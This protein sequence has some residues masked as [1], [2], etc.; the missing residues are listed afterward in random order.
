M[1]I[2]ENNTITD[3]DGNTYNV[4]QIGKQLWTA[5]NLN[6]SKYRNGDEIPQVQDAEEWAHLETGAWCYYDNKDENGTSYGKL[7]NWYAFNDPRGLAPEGFYIPSDMEWKTLT[8]YLGGDN[9]A[10]GKMKEKGS[11]HFDSP[12]NNAT[13]ESVFSGLTGGCRDI[14]LFSGMDKIG[15]WWASSE[16]S[17]N[18]SLAYYQKIFDKGESIM[19]D[20]DN[21]KCG[22]SVRLLKDSTIIKK[23]KIG[24]AVI[25]KIIISDK[26]GNAYNGVQIGKQLWM[27]ENL[28]VSKYRNGDEIPQ[29]QDEKEWGE[30]TTGAWC[31][32]KNDKEYGISYG[33][34]YNWHAINDPRGLA[35]EGFHI[36][37]DLELITLTEYI[38]PLK[39][40]EKL[41]LNLFRAS[42]GGYR[43]VHSQ[44]YEFSAGFWWSST[45]GFMSNSWEQKLRYY[46][47]YPRRYFYDKQNGLSVRCI[48]D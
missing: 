21:K 30:L 8:K 15:V 10:G 24:S 19:G 22:F 4:V 44:F 16:Y 12:N 13:N 23:A 20:Y 1:E 11:I 25:E 40:V 17:K 37:S 7:Y 42:L 45:E 3:I 9:V 26:N 2:T 18:F 48:K 39:G 35:P 33:K 46:N 29:V 43:T 28:N 32:Y 27:T 47:D 31:Y 5:E 41:K 36:P 34:L 14:S 6:V 38:E